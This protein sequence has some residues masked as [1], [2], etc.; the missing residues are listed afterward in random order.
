MLERFA[1]NNICAFISHS[2]REITSQASSQVVLCSFVVCG[3]AFISRQQIKSISALLE[4]EA[5]T[6]ITFMMIEFDLC[7]VPSP[8]IRFYLLF[9]ISKGDFISI[10]FALS[11]NCI[12]SL[13]GWIGVRTHEDKHLERCFYKLKL[14]VV[15]SYCFGEDLFVGTG[16]SYKA[17]ICY[18]RWNAAN[19]IFSIRLLSAF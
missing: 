14:M 17:I 1:I 2:T 4:S 6:N 10:S 19:K 18:S 12:I 3:V 11:W 7:G 13:W 8:E 16:R 5:T 9:F 15:S